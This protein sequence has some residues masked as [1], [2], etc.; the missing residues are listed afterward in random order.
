KPRTYAQKARQARRSR[1]RNV[2]SKAL[3]SVESFLFFTLALLN[4]YGV[5][6]TRIAP[7]IYKMVYPH[8]GT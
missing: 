5:A 3:D 4:F 7:A 6:S 1:T 8:W 2:G